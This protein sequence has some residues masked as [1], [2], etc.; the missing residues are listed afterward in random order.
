MN[1]HMLHL[2]FV[3]VALACA[4][5]SQVPLLDLRTVDVAVYR[6]VLDSMFV[7][8]VGGRITQLVVTDSTRV[9]RRKILV[10]DLIDGFYKLLGVDTVAVRDFEARS[11]DALALKELSRI[12]LT[13]AVTLVTD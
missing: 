8:D 12:R 7:R 11:R 3:L 5:A 2:S 13:T 1:R 4:H 9:W 6:T 10:D